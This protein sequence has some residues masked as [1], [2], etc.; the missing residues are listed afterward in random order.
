MKCLFYDIIAKVI[1]AQRFLASALS[2][3][4]RKC[5]ETCGC[6]TF[7]DICEGCITLLLSATPHSITSSALVSNVGGTVRPSALAVLRLITSS[8]LVGCM[9]GRS[10]GMA[11]LRMRPT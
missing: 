3:L 1:A 10:D 8:N 9:I 5:H 7:C 6:V 2:A 11:P 4:A